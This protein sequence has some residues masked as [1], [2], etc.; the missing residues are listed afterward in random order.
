MAVTINQEK[1]SNGWKMDVWC[2][3]TDTKPTQA[4]TPR[5]Y[6]GETIAIPNGSTLTEIDTGNVYFFNE[7]SGEWAFQFC[8]QG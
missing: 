6:G 1:V 4:T 8:V 7:T 3:S 5:A 2:L